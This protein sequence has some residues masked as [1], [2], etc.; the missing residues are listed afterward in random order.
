MSACPRPTSSAAK[1]TASGLRRSGSGR[2]ADPAATAAAAF[3]AAL[4]KAG[5]AVAGAPLETAAPAD[6]TELASL[7][8]DPLAEI[9][10]H[11]LETSDNEAAEVLA[12]HVGLAVD[13]DGSFTGGARAVRQVL[14][15]CTR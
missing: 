15:D 11:T 6:A 3:A 7:D 8:S 14:A 2:V 10:E 13:D 4:A 5:V 12:R 1:A 9:V